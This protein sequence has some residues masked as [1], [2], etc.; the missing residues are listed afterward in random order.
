MVTGRAKIAG[1]IGYPV[2]HSLSPRLHGYW[3]E[4]YS[5]DGAYIPLQTAPETVAAAFA[6]LQALG[7]RGANVTLP[8]K[9][10]ALKAVHKATPAAQ[11]IGVV[12]T[13]ICTPDGLV[14]DNTDGIGFIGN[15]DHKAPQ[16]RDA[17][18]DGTAAVIGAGGAAQAVVYA[19][20]Q[21]GVAR[22]ELYN[23]TASKAEATAARFSD[24][25][26]K[27]MPWAEMLRLD[28]DLI[29]NTSSLGMEGQPPL[30]VDLTGVRPSAL[31]TDIV[32]TPL[33]TPLLAAARA[34]GLHAVDGL[35]MLVHQ[36]RPGFEAWFGVKPDDIDGAEAFLREAL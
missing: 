2:G 32:Y 17:C 15:L 33:E 21:A 36:A 4:K 19:L 30:P 35:G 28:A 13:L 14:G 25:P 9:A 27:V 31:V 24:A 34:Q 1:V 16:W 26:I 29:V 6:G 8:H 7:F 23:R 22:I 11:A 12:N 5:V 10:A 18:S 3:L 20:A